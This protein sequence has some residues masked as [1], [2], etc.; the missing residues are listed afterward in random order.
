MGMYYLGNKRSI[1]K[2]Y[3]DDQSRNHIDSI[4]KISRNILSLNEL[5]NS[6][7]SSR[8]PSLRYPKVLNTDIS[9]SIITSISPDNSLKKLQT[10]NKM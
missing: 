9:H 7:H 2:R 1:S 3:G 6:V 4:S 10:F 8:K 5:D